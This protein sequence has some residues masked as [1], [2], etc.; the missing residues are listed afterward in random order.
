MVLPEI[1]RHEPIE[2]WI[3]DDRALPRR[4][5]IRLDLHGN[6]VASWASKTIVKSPY[7]F[8]CISSCELAGGVSPVSPKEW[9]TGRTHWRKAGVPK[10]MTFKTKPAIDLDHLRWVCAA[11]LPRGVVLMDADLRNCCDVIASTDR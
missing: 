3:I 1:E 10:E 9:V 4:V 8:A 11:G 7:L 2:A 5:G 6:I